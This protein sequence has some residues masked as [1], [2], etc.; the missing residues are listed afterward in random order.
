MSVIDIARR[1]SAAGISALAALAV[2]AGAGHARTATHPSKRVHCSLHVYSQTPTSLRG[3]DFGL[4]KC[5]KPFGK[6]VQY[7]TYT[8]SVTPPKASARGPFEW[9]FDEGTVH[10]TFSFAGT[11]SSPTTATFAGT[12]KITGGTGAFENARARTDLTCTT[13]DAGKTFTCTADGKGTGL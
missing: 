6:G 8:E 10:G 1:G 4:V 13:T 3:F 7:D 12:L 2:A 5:S 9:F 11:F